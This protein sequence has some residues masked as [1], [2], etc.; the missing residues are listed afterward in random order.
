M[1]SAHKNRVVLRGGGWTRGLNNSK[2]NISR[3]NKRYAGSKFAT[4]HRWLSYS[5]DAP[6]MMMYFVLL[7]VNTLLRDT[8]DTLLVTSSAGVEAIPLLKTWAVIPSSVAF[9]AL[10]SWLAARLSKRGLFVVLLSGFSLWFLSF[11]LF[12]FP[13]GGRTVASSV[14]MRVVMPDS[15]AH[16][17]PL[18]K[19]WTLC[20]FYVASELWASAIC[21]LLFWSV[22]NDVVRLDSAKTVY[23]LI[24]LA[25]NLGM[26]LAGRILLLFA[27]QR[28]RAVKAYAYLQHSHQSQSNDTSNERVM[29]ELKLNME[30][31]PAL[32]FP[33][34][35][36][37]WIGTLVVISLM[38]V[39]S[40]LLLTLLYDLTMQ[41]ALRM[42]TIRRIKR[43]RSA[44]GELF[45]SSNKK[46]VVQKGLSIPSSFS[47]VWDNPSLRCVAFMVISYGICSSVLEVTWKQQVKL[48]FERTEYSKFMG[49]FWTYTGI[50]SV[51]MLLCGRTIMK[52]LGYSFGVVFT[53]LVMAATGITFFLADLYAA[54]GP[55]MSTTKFTSYAGAIAVLLSKASK[56]SFFDA[57][58]EMIFIP[59]GA[60]EKAIGKASIDVVAYRLSKS[61]GSFI[62]QF[63]LF[64]FGALGD[65][66]ASLFLCLV[67]TA[68]VGLWIHA[69]ISASHIISRAYGRIGTDRSQDS[70]M[71]ADEP[72]PATSGDDESV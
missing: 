62:L 52:R 12:V 16:F 53:P 66:H 36:Q 15:L 47:M 64:A 11:S 1:S 42:G 24:S 58:K 29:N 30:G 46:K 40:V 51:T 67:F 6:L 39:F 32:H 43:T 70:S 49:K 69:A 59:L 54:Y 10:Y 48:A 68:V 13:L 57:T 63:A 28:D 72:A 27:N 19:N 23:P 7:L 20:L 26:I 56:Y 8:K 55:N 4:L 5:V 44:S 35:N 45:R 14:A 31:R 37:G 71:S 18:I 34:D 9:F 38:I 22:C 50:G 21:Q 60:R 17:R 25:G 41:R 61:G 3:L 2:K 65:S 33:D